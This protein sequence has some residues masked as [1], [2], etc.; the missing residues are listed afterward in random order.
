MRPF[1]L[2]IVELRVTLDLLDALHHLQVVLEQLDII[3]LLLVHVQ[4]MILLDRILCQVRF[5]LRS[6]YGKMLALLYLNE[7]IQ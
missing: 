7:S 6:G 1:G 4:R 2:V 5:V 3:L